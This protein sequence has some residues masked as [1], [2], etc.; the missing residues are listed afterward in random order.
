MKN[1][2][3]GYESKNKKDSKR[4]ENINEYFLEKYNAIC[5]PESEVKSRNMVKDIDIFT[6][7]GIKKYR[8]Q[9]TMHDYSDKYYKSLGKTFATFSIAFLQVLV[10]RRGIFQIVNCLYQDINNI[11]KQIYT[12]IHKNKNS[13][14]LCIDPYKLKIEKITMSNYFQNKMYITILFSQNGI[15]KSGRFLIL[16]IVR[17]NK[18]SP[19]FVKNIEVL[20]DNC[21]IEKFGSK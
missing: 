5:F 20:L 10:Q 17:E 4:A 11:E 7:K 18:N 12:F 6:H 2:Y 1:K 19:Y 3:I 16:E 9:K 15:S 21:K 14:V 8:M 13:K